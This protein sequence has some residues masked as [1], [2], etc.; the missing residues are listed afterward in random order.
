MAATF[1]ER[2][3]GILDERHIQQK[4]IAAQLHVSSAVFSAWIKCKS[5]PSLETFANLCSILNLSADYLLG[6]SDTLQPAAKKPVEVKKKEPEVNAITSSSIL[7]GLPARDLLSDMDSD[8]IC[9]AKSY[10]AY[11]R[12]QQNQRNAAKEKKKAKAKA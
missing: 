3:K 2:L 4:E 11:L 5:E 1:A 6:L 7:G 8:L 10:I 12:E 9:Q